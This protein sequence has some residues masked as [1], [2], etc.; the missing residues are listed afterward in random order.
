MEKRRQHRES[1]QKQLAASSYASHASHAS[2]ASHS[3]AAATLT[4]CNA[5]QVTLASEAQVSGHEMLCLGVDVVARSSQVVSRRTRPRI[6]D[7]PR[8]AG[9]ST[10]N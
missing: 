1:A 4:Q 3:A 7:R 9:I 6:A 8:I 2:Q 10:P 5:A